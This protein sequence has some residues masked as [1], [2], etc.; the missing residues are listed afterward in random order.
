MN[1]PQSGVTDEKCKMSLLQEKRPFT[2]KNDSSGVDHLPV[3]PINFGICEQFSSNIRLGR[4]SRGQFISQEHLQTT[5][6]SKR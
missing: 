3:L 4:G 2:G 6:I 5:L 1:P